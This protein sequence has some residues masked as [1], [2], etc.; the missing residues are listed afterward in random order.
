MKK[1]ILV[2]TDASFLSSG[3]GVYAKEVLTR[4]H[5]S[6]KY[7]V[8]ELGCYATMSSPEIKNIPWKFYP[9][10]VDTNDKRYE[11]Y[12][13]IPN[14]QFGVW[15]FN[16]ACAHFQP[17]IVCTWTDYWMFSYQETSPFRK[18]FSWILMPMVDSAPQKLEWLHTFCNAEKVIPY[19][20]WAKKVLSDSCGKQIKL[21]D[22]TAG[23]G[24]NNYE[25]FP[26]SNRSKNRI[27]TLGSDDIDV[28]GCVMRNQKRKLFADTLE[29]FRKYLDRLISEN[30]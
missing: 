27:E 1:R 17:H 10:A 7:E 28:I 29:A 12:K 24:I 20:E 3:F 13:S 5:N 8:A 4:L 9:N 19:T 2:A 11:N 22:K 21:F 14:N 16:K 25:F 23:A 18:F 6:G 15:R 26:M 30:K